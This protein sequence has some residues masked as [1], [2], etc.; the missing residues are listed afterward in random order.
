VSAPALTLGLALAV[1]L[2]AGGA[3]TAFT[4]NNALKKI[5]AVLTALVGAALSLSLVGAPSVAI[6]GAVAI[7]LAYCVIGVSV[8]VRLQEA[9]GSVDLNEADAADEQ[10]EP[11][12]PSA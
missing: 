9:Y 2:L 1:A 6:I 5:A 7:A 3:V 11:R 4:V 10:D 12:E 8:A